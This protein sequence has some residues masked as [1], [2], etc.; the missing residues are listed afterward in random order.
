LSVAV[1]PVSEGQAVRVVSGRKHCVLK[2]LEQTEGRPMVHLLGLQIDWPVAAA[3]A[4][5]V[6]SLIHRME[7][8][9][10]EFEPSFV[11]VN[12]VV[13]P[14]GGFEGKLCR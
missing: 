1:S 12:E 13:I 4:F 9:E 10:R 11:E 6:G 3:V 7:E 2:P 5:G 14:P 8:L